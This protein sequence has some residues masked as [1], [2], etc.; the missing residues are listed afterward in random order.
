MNSHD[1]IKH[2]VET[3]YMNE[4]FATQVLCLPLCLIHVESGFIG[5]GFLLS[6][7]LL[8][9]HERHILCVSLETRYGFH[10]TTAKGDRVLG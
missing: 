7:W 8:L 2:N 5:L 6:P 10:S 3:N 1:Q 4:S 9:E